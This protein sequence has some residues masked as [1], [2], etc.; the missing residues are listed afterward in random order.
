MVR[1]REAHE[2]VKTHPYRANQVGSQKSYEKAFSQLSHEFSMTLYTMFRGAQE[3]D[4]PYGHRPGYDNP[5]RVEDFEGSMI[6]E[7]NTILYYLQMNEGTPEQMVLLEKYLIQIH[8]FIDTGKWTKFFV[9]FMDRPTLPKGYTVEREYSAKNNAFILT[10]DYL[11]EHGNHVLQG[12]LKL[13][14]LHASCPPSPASPSDLN[15]SIRKA[16]CYYYDRIK[17]LGVRITV[18]EKALEDYMGG[19]A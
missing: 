11:K 9:W 17:N 3:G 10:D 19:K 13:A 14:K 12:Y 18:D 16:C 7:L 8:H 15:E 2:R 6:H 1:L 5:D 4:G